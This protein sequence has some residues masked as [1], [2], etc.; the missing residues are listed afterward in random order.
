MIG[1]RWYTARS[2]TVSLVDHQWQ[3][4]APVPR[5]IKASVQPL[6]ARQKRDLPEGIAARGQYL[7]MTREA[8]VAWTAGTDTAADTV[9]VKGVEYEVHAF[10]DHDL[11]APIPH[12]E[13]VLVT[14]EDA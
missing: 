2:R 14:P 5:Q 12:Y 11:G 10:E 6:T 7:C 13:Y 9:E 4:S 8:L 3:T 1:M